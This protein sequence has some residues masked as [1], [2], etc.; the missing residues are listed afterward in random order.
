MWV[1]SGAGVLGCGEKWTSKKQTSGGKVWRENTGTAGVLTSFP[2]C[3][4]FRS[5]VRW[6]L[7][8]G[9]AETG[10]SPVW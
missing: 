8:P 10:F 7:A 6:I 9:D 4:H 3:S 2:I 5:C 1:H